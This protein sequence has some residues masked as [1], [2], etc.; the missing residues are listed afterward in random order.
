MEVNIGGTINN[1]DKISSME[2]SCPPCRSICYC[3]CPLLPLASFHCVYRSGRFETY[4]L[5]PKAQQSPLDLFAV[6][7]P[8]LFSAPQPVFDGS[9]RDRQTD[10]QQ[11]NRPDG[12]CRAHWMC[13]QSFLSI[14]FPL[15]LW[16]VRGC[17]LL[18]IHWYRMQSPDW[19]NYSRKYYLHWVHSDFFATSHFR[20][21]VNA[22]LATPLVGLSC[23]FFEFIT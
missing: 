23:T 22:Y 16:E 4:T 1:Y 8:L 14:H 21:C 3:I 11:I 10:I 19:R 5:L 20:Q 17:L 18:K 9:D 13:P 2:F 6:C 7:R 15:S 12:V